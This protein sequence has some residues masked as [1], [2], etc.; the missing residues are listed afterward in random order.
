MDAKN[1]RYRLTFTLW[2]VK[3]V[4]FRAAGCS[5]VQSREMEPR[6]WRPKWSFMMILPFD[7]RRSAESMA[8]ADLER[9]LRANMSMSALLDILDATDNRPKAQVHELRPPALGGAAL[10]RGFQD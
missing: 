7:I 6:R 10:A 4:A 5:N 9:R 1:V 3:C 2:V 8:R